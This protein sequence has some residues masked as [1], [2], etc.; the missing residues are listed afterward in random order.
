MLKCSTCGDMAIF[1]T[2]ADQR[3][4]F[5]C[6]WHVENVKRKGKN[7]P[8]VSEEEFQLNKEYS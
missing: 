7:L 1:L 2:P 4:H 3:V 6:E 8:L 5:K